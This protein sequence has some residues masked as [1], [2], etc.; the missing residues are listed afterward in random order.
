MTRRPREPA[1]LLIP[2]PLEEI[3]TST[4]DSTPTAVLVH[5]AFV[6]ASSWNGV[7]T[8]LTAA[9]LDVVAP[10]NLLRGAGV[11]AAYLTGFA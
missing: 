6:D 7:I 1:F 10:P 11:D 4:P 3:L 9:G 5:G 2:V 8:E